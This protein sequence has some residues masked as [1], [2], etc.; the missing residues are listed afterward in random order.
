MTEKQQYTSL[1]AIP[2]ILLTRK[3]AFKVYQDVAQRWQGYGMGY[4]FWLA[5]I[6][7][8]IFTVFATVNI[9]SFSSKNNIQ[10]I[11]K[12]IPTFSIYNNEL[13]PDNKQDKYVIYNEK[14]KPIAVYLNKNLDRETVHEIFIKNTKLGVIF[15]PNYYYILNNR[16]VDDFNETKLKLD[17]RTYTGGNFTLTQEQIKKIYPILKTASLF[18]IPPILL[19]SM[20]LVYFIVNIIYA[21]L[22]SIIGILLRGL[23]S[24]NKKILPYSGIFRLST[25]S[26]TWIT[27]LWI[28][29]FIP[30]LNIINFGFLFKFIMTSCI[31]LIILIYLKPV[32]NKKEGTD[33]NIES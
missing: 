14:N 1:T 2:A 26:I 13:Y 16:T 25:V 15:M 31:L 32:L 11:V 12:Q 20:T 24:I 29:S 9:Y 21:F 10:H 7:S 4:L 17:V 8:T 5:L 27:L 3:K 19:I 22:V 6:A 18:A 28:S 33:I 30:G 23:L